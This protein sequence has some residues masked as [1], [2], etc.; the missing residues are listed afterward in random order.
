MAK[1]AAASLDIINP[2]LVDPDVTAN[3]RTAIEAF[4]AA[5]GDQPNDRPRT[6]G[7]TA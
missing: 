6:P 4:A 2:R 5:A 1:A 3:A 7:A